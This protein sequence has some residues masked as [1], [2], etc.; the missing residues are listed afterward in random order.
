M[1]E[2]G[3]EEFNFDDLS[4]NN[5]ITLRKV[6]CEYWIKTGNDIPIVG[7]AAEQVKSYLKRATADWGKFEEIGIVDW[8]S[9][10]V[11]L[12]VFIDVIKQDVRY[13]DITFLSQF[14]NYK[15]GDGGYPERRARLWDK[16]GTRPAI[17][18]DVC[19]YQ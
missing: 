5:L 4:L 15:A 12:N 9:K 13:Y 6:I 18:P 19:L 14:F 7:E 17:P 10:E 1:K 2:R 16:G 11:T 8:I 3:L